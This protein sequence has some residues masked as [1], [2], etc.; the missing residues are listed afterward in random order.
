MYYLLYYILLI[1]NFNNINMDKQ[2]TLK[3]IDTLFENNG[4]IDALKLIDEMLNQD[5]QC[6][7][8]QLCKAICLKRMKSYDE[9]LKC[10][11]QSI[12]LNPYNGIAFS[13]KGN[14]RFETGH[15][16][17]AVMCYN[18]ANELNAKVNFYSGE[19]ANFLIN[20]YENAIKHYESSLKQAGKSPEVMTKRKSSLEAY[21][22]LKLEKIFEG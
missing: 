15:F 20:E 8:F 10:F 19:Y 7:D 4:Y 21:E 14:L 13:A 22:K 2:A 3:K 11:D 9:S 12:F 18:Q 17:D 1:I 6:E 5:S 16:S